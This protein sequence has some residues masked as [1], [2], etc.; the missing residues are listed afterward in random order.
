MFPYSYSCSRCSQ[1]T[2]GLS[3]GNPISCHDLSVGNPILSYASSSVHLKSDF[4]PRLTNVTRRLSVGNPICFVPRL[5][6]CP[7]TRNFRRDSKSFSERER[8]CLQGS[9]DN[10]CSSSKCVYCTLHTVF[11]AFVSLPTYF[12]DNLAHVQYGFFFI[13]STFSDNFCG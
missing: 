6:V 13:R 9:L 4:V 10:S 11:S 1:R 5:I 8:Y 7:S 2:R 3:V 12:V